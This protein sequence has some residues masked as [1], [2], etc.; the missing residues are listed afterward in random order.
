MPYTVTYEGKEYH[1]E[2]INMHD[3]QG[4]KSG[5]V[6]G[7][8]EITPYIKSVVF[9]DGI[10]ALKGQ[11]YLC[12]CKK[13]TIPKSVSSIEYTAFNGI[14][15]CGHEDE[16]ETPYWQ[17]L[18]ANFKAFDLE[19]FIVDKDNMNYTAK[20]GLLYTKDMKMLISCPRGKKGVIAIPEGV[21]TLANA[22]FGICNRLTEIQLPSTIRKI[23]YG[24]GRYAG[25]H[26]CLNLEKVNIPTEL[27]PILHAFSTD[28]ASVQ[29]VWK[30]RFAP[31]RSGRSIR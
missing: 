9:S 6:G 10:K 22:S 19:E 30:N 29:P 20:D 4:P 11:F 14:I 15:D 23:E 12:Y 5:N 13:V 3:L 16:V 31:K 18:G 21:E 24:Y 26:Y 8:T 25:F 1:C 27:L 2:T 7:E 28:H 17:E